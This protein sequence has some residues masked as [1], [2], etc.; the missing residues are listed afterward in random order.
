[1]WLNNKNC[2]KRTIVDANSTCWD[3]EEDWSNFHSPYKQPRLAGSYPSAYETLT[4][5]RY[6]WIDRPKIYGRRSLDDFRNSSTNFNVENRSENQY[7]QR[8][9]RDNSCVGVAVGNSFEELEEQNSAVLVKEEVTPNFT[10]IQEKS[11]L[12]IEPSGDDSSMNN[13]SII[14]RMSF[15]VSSFWSFLHSVRV[16]IIDF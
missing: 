16:F 15:R 14:E 2:R 6:T 13:I 12:E 5:I 1:M 9:D 8:A 10:G 3:Q 4:N 11:L 7:S